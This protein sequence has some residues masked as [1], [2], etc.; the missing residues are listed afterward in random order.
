MSIKIEFPYSTFFFLRREG[1]FEGDLK[2]VNTSKTHLIFSSPNL[3]DF[4]RK[5]FI[6]IK[7]NVFSIFFLT[8]SSIEFNI[9]K[10]HICPFLI[11]Y[12]L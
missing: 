7:F 8:F 9:K 11:N 3:R 4:Q 6:L 2:G 1:I 5:C 12:K 10:L